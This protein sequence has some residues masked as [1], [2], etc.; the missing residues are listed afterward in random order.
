MYPNSKETSKKGFYS[1]VFLFVFWKLKEDVEECPWYLL[2]V[3]KSATV[4]KYRNVG[5]GIRSV[6]YVK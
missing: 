1:F 3:G 4:K 2:Q 6:A 5:P